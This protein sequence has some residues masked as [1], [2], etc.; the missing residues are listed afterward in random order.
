MKPLSCAASLAS[1]ALTGPP[2]AIFTCSP[3]IAR[4]AASV[5]L[6]ILAA[7]AGLDARK[8]LIDLSLMGPL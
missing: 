7:A 6:P 2:S 5:Y 3:S 8:A 4:L 1:N